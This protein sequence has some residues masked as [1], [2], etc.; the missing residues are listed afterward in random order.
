VVKNE[1]VLHAPMSMDTGGTSSS[2]AGPVAASTPMSGSA[3]GPTLDAEMGEGVDI[4]AFFVTCDA[5]LFGVDAHAFV[6]YRIMVLRALMCECVLCWH[7]N[8]HIC[9][10]SR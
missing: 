4:G 9:A 3:A 6:C 10:E 8:E 2:S 5:R 1:P 7:G